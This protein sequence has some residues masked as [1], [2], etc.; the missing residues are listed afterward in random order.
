V[1]ST[2]GEILRSGLMLLRD[3][4]GYFPQ[5]RAA[6]LA[7][8]DLPPEVAG[9]LEQMSGRINNERMQR[10]NLE[11]LDPS[12]SFAE[13][14]SAFLLEEGLVESATDVPAF[15][16]RLWRNTK[17]HLKLTGIALALA[18]FA[19]VG[20]AATVHRYS[21]AANSFLYFTGLLQTVPSI[22]LLALLIPWFGIGQTPAIIALF[23]YSLLPIARGTIT[24]LLAIPPGYRQVAAAMAM[25]RRQETR[26][27]LMPL[28][29]PHVIAG[30]RTAAVISIGTA[31]LAAFIGAGGLGDP[32]VTGLALNDS[33]MILEGALPAAGL[34]ILTELA[35]TGLERWL[36][37]PHMRGRQQ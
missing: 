6:F 5:Y 1:Y 14:A 33:S 11:V 37:P 25:T 20:I 2:D 3:D 31:T 30:I 29:M 9:I 23:L 34:A 21:R 18:I 32:I 10:L 17:Q 24:A 7:R 28:A 8:R 13:V 22:A 36:V 19:G 12:V 15:M 4:L 35:F 26:Y 16:P 27:V